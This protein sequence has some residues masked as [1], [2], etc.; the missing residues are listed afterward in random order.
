MLLQTFLALKHKKIKS[1]EKKDIDDIIIINIEE[2]QRSQLIKNY[3]LIYRRFVH[4]ESK[5]LIKLYE[6]IVRR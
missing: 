2:S 3:Y 1:N 6:V 5:I 4:F